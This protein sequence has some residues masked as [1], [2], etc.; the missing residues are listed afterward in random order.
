MSS[1]VIITEESPLSKDL[2]LLFARHSA[3][4]HAETPPESIYMMDPSALAAA[5]VRL[6]VIRE[7]GQPIAMGALKAISPELAEIKSMHVLSEARGRGLS[8]ILLAHL[9]AEAQA[10]GHRQLSLE[11]GREKGFAAATGLYTKAGFT[12]CGPFGS[13]SLDPNSLY[14]TRAL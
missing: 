7:A 6:F 1:A 14:M 3:A 8:T 2:E 4:M 5:D 12:E 10:A 9:I 13:Y 11:T